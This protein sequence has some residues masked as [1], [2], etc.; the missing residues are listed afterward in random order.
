M[1]G[2]ITTNNKQQKKQIKPNRETQKPAALQGLSSILQSLLSILGVD[3]DTSSAASIR[4]L[5]RDGVR[6]GAGDST[7]LGTAVNID[8]V[9]YFS[10]D[11]NVYTCCLLAPRR[12]STPKFMSLD[13]IF[14]PQHACPYVITTSKLARN[15]LQ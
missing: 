3:M 4:S 5:A 2:W 6:A 13:Y 8:Q 11:T 15:F 9:T 12:D 7:L 10:Q 1:G 14:V